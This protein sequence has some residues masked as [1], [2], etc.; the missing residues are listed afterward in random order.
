MT[1]KVGD[2]VIKNPETWQPSEFD[3]WGAGEGTGT[4]V[5]IIDETLVDVKWKCGRA[6]QDENELLL[7]T[8]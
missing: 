6:S 4:V 2:R 3:S 7:V 1:L 5:G 8:D